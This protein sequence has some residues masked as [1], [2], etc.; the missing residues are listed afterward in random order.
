MYKGIHG[1]VSSV[2]LNL[3]DKIRIVTKSGVTLVV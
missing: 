1:H 3:L 2:N